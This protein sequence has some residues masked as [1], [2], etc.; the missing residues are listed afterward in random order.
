LRKYRIIAR[1]ME[2]KEDS[3]NDQL[4]LINQLES[5]P[6]DNW[7]E[8][9]L[10]EN[11]PLVIAFATELTIKGFSDTIQYEIGLSQQSSQNRT[12]TEDVEMSAVVR[13]RIPARGE[14][15]VFVHNFDEGSEVYKKIGVLIGK[16]NKY[17]WDK[18]RLAEESRAMEIEVDY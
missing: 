9:D 5:V 4:R 6:F 10:S 12:P 17:I 2:R 7:R 11:D 13:A 15:F 3:P 16:I 8:A 1:T 18:K 14:G